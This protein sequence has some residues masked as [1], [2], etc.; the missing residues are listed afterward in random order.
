MSKVIDSR[1]FTKKFRI[2]NNIK[3]KLGPT[4]FKFACNYIIYYPPGSNRDS[5]FIYDNFITIHVLRYGASNLLYILE[6][7]ATVISWRS[8]NCN[9]DNLT[10]FYRLANV[11]RKLKPLIIG[12]SLH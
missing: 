10:F 5:A 8:A 7:G 3:V 11:S 4:F 12:V 2:R 9:E 6:V 1:T